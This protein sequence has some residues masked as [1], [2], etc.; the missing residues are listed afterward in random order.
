MISRL[1]FGAKVGARNEKQEKGACQLWTDAAGR[2]SRGK[3][4]EAE[5]NDATLDFQ[6]AQTT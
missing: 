2:F 4:R 1:I 5:D 6:C 3:K